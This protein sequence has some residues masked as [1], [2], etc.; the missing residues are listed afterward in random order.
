MS[1]EMAY[2][3]PLE[4]GNTAEITAMFNPDQITYTKSNTWN[5]HHTNGQN[6]PEV[7]FASGVP[8]TLAVTLLFDGTEDGQNVAKIINRLTELT[9]VNK[10]LKGRRSSANGGDA[11]SNSFQGRPPTV[12]FHWGN[13]LSFDA[14]VQKVISRF[15]M[16]LD[17][18]TP[19]RASVDVTFMQIADENAFPTQNP[20]SGGRT[21][22]R[23]HR[24]APRETLDQVA[25][26]NFGRTSLWRALA[27]FNGIDDPM[28]IQAGD[29]ILLPASIDDLKALA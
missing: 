4:G 5:L 2:I 8:A 12:R 3:K 18:G 21:G 13:Y 1:L 15:S 19:V 10:E 26:A 9:K 22:E 6:L 16:F 24:L 17:D 29:A 25:Y 23:V 20:T 28:R 27:A 7:S 11:P 14:V